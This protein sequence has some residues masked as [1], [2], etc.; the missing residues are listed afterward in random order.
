MGQ[1][2]IGSRLPIT[3]PPAVQRVAQAHVPQ[4]TPTVCMH[5]QAL[6]QR[7]V[8]ILA[9]AVRKVRSN[10]PEGLPPMPEV[11]IPDPGSVRVPSPPPPLP[12]NAAGEL[13]QQ[14]ASPHG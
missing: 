13:E 4:W 7:S 12:L 2:C 11:S 5:V 3:G 14:A 10:F 8:K 9:G 6:Q 1:T